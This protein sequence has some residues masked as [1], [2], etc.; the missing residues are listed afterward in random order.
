MDS[1]FCFLA[2]FAIPKIKKVRR[3]MKNSFLKERT[4]SNNP[5]WQQAIKREKE[6]YGR[7]NDLRSEFERDYTRLLHCRAYRRLKNKTQVFF[8][9][10]ND[11]AC[12]RIEHVGHVASVANIIARYLGLNDELTHAIAIGHDIGHAP[13]G[14]SG[15]TILNSILGKEENETVP[16]KFWHERNSLFFADYIE[17]LDDPEGVKR[18]LNLTYA[19]RDGLICHCGEIDQQ[20]IRPRKDAM[21]LY[22]IKRPG[23]TQPFTWEGCIVKLSDKIAFLGR[24]IE[25]AKMYH[26]L[27]M[28]SYRQLREIVMS[29]LGMK[30][31]K[32]TNG[33]TFSTLSHRS[34]RAVNTTV[35]INDMIV[36]LCENSTPETGLC[37]SPNYAA[38]ISELKSFCFKNIYNHWRLQEFQNYADNVLKTIY[39]TLMKAEPYARNGRMPFIADDFP[40]L[41]KAFEEWLICHSNYR[42]ADSGE[43]LRTKMRYATETIFDVHS[44]SSFQKCVIEFISGMTDDYAIKCFNEIISF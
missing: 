32:T 28:G 44:E 20:G 25:D 10:S 31:Q 1:L 12:T 29:T 42:K 22:D 21:N 37:F 30:R 36:D 39:R 4:D 24:D 16:K 34:G 19:V 8:D 2:I 7:G 18:P 17:T 33:E 13:F 38:F 14:H 43:D 5:K 11:H 9:P 6:M 15:E 35:L 3:A 26:L 27:D 40:M 23:M 41:A